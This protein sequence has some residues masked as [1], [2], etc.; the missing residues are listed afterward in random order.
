[1]V[2]N[3]KISPITAIAPTKAAARTAIKSDSPPLSS[4]VSKGSDSEPLS[5]REVSQE[6]LT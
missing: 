2:L 3:R 4:T 5:Y 6:M 1:M